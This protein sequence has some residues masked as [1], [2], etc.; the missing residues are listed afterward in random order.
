MVAIQPARPSLNITTASA[1]TLIID[2]LANKTIAGS[3]WTLL[4]GGSSNYLALE[5][6]TFPLRERI[7]GREAL[8]PLVAIS[9]RWCNLCG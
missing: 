6:Q 7:T 4:D 2:A 3:R 9:V 8:E 1:N 5:N